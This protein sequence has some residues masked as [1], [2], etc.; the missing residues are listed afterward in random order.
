[1]FKITMKNLKPRIMLVACMMFT[2]NL[3]IAEP[4]HAQLKGSNPKTEN[5]NTPK[6]F[7]PPGLPGSPA[8]TPIDGGLGVLAFAGAAYAMKKVR[9]RHAD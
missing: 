7:A 8:Q 6:A 1:M 5:L 2:I 3:A 4:S 9:N